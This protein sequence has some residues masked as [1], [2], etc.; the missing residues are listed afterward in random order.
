MLKR[1]HGSA[2]KNYAVKAADIASYVTKFQVNMFIAHGH[3]CLQPRVAVYNPINLTQEVLPKL[4]V[5]LDREKRELQD[6]S[7][8]LSS[9]TLAEIAAATPASQ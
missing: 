2:L 4:K 5:L 6:P 3:S 7:A 9:E 1:A 8:P